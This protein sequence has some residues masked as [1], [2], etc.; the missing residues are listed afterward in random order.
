MGFVET[1]SE[2]QRLA[3][4][5]AYLDR[6]I[7]PAGRV[8]ELARAGQLDFR[9][10]PLP[11]FQVSESTVR[12]FAAATRRRRA[13]KAVTAVAQMDHADAVESL[14]RRLM[15]ATD[16]ALRSIERR[17]K[18]SKASVQ[19][20]EIREAAR[21][22]RELSA[23]P[24]P[25]EGRSVAP[26]QR[27]PDGQRAGGT[28]RGGLAGSLLAAHRRNPAPVLN[29]SAE[30]SAEPANDEIESHRDPEPDPMATLVAEVRERLQAPSDETG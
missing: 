24:G 8:A 19:W 15:S 28:S 3:I 22:L 23:L 9:G 13:G 11:A 25:K 18:R 26:G 29:G 27:G 21:A 17:Q 30:V 4:A 2:E 14:R 7:R 20:A 12:S 1:Y 16:E 6:G 10:E 5:E